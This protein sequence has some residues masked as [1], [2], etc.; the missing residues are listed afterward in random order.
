M[1]TISKK[2][3]VAQKPEVAKPL[4]ESAATVTAADYPQIPLSQ[5]V[6]SPLNYRKYIDPKALEEFAANL[7]IY[8]VISPVTLRPAP[9]GGYE[10]VVGERRLKGSILAG[11]QT[12]PAVIRELSDEVVNEIQ[13]SENVQRENPHPFHE[14]QAVTRMQQ[15][16]KSID[17]IAAHLGK[18]KTF[19]YSRI[20]LSG[21]I[22]P[23][24]D[25]FLACKVTIQEAYEVAT[26]SQQ[27]QYDFYESH[28]TDWQDDDFK[29]PGRYAI[30]RFRYELTNAPFDIKDKKLVA[31]K[32]ACTSCPLN[33][34]TLKTLFPELAK[35]AVC[36]GAE[37]YHNKCRAHYEQQI[38]EAA[39]KMPPQALVYENSHFFEEVAPI[40]DARENLKELPRYAK[41][42]IIEINAP[43]APDKNDYTE[44][45][46]QT[47]YFDEQGYSQAL[48][49]YNSDLDDYH[50]TINSGETF[51][52][53]LITQKAVRFILFILREQR[54][55]TQDQPTLTAK[56]VQ[57][58]IKD[59]T[60]TAEM[61]GEEIK[62]ISTREIRNQE[63]DQD[64]IQLEMYAQFFDRFG[65]LE[66]NTGM[67][68]ADKVALRLIVFQALD[69]NVRHDVEKVLGMLGDSL[70]KDHFF[71]T[72]SGLTEAQFTYMV[73][74]ALFGNTSSKHPDN[75]D[76]WCLMGI[77]EQAG[78]DVDAIRAAQQQIAETRQV[79]TDARIKELEQRREILAALEA[80]QQPQAAA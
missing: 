54:Q 8:G 51:S 33:S 62:R 77:A 74:M 22:E 57:Q 1:K 79:R 11:L 18:S 60:I 9:S 38:T 34:A 68:A 25:I 67:T 46:G 48:D 55:Q 29:F 21:L 16:G 30:N 66:H 64:K 76:G 69:Y 27:S 6:V 37:C 2:K 59:G 3:S 32:G 5:I 43:A 42:G 15:S 65:E 63:I 13:L 72:L 50:G 78:L 70:E 49:E 7:A 17:E 23:W 44:K 80:Q 53:L 20:K 75:I 56:V 39:E 52:G 36:S 10:L 31:E 45:D 26:L 14:A 4:P 28:A 47:E 71:E 24:Q 40:I 19:V 61:L 12:I 58:A 73:R 41:S 35:Q